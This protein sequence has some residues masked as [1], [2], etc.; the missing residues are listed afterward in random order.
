MI[1]TEVVFNEIVET[2][3]DIENISFI[4]SM[5]LEE[6]KMVRVIIEEIEAT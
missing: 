1:P 3:H 4:L 2:E 5:L 6:G